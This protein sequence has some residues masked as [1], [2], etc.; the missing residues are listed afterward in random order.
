LC[1]F[2]FFENCGKYWLNPDPEPELE[3]EPRLFSEVG[4]GTGI[5]AANHYGPQHCQIHEKKIRLNTKKSSKDVTFYMT[6][7]AELP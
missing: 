2:L 5:S 6:D 1:N 3:P 7:R 4:T